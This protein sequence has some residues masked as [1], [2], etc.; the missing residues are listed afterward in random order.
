[1]LEKLFNEKTI[2]INS[3]KEITA[4]YNPEILNSRVGKILVEKINAPIESTSIGEI[5]P[6]FEGPSPSGEV[7]NLSDL[8][9]KVTII[10]I[11]HRKRTL[12]ICDQIIEVKDGKILKN[13]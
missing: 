2:D 10:F 1:M 6:N 5:A 8:K 13:K 11:S 9:G 12:S 4:A 3:A 7:L